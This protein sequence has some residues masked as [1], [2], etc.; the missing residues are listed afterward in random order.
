MMYNITQPEIETM[1]PNY[2]WTQIWKNVAF[3]PINIYDR[4]IMFKY[5]HE[6]LT[7]SKK[8]YSMGLKTSPLCNK[9]GVEESNVHL[10]LYC[11]KVQTSVNWMRRLI[12][13]LCNMDIGNN[14]LRCLFLDFPKV[15]KTVQNTLN[16][17]ICS[18]VSWIWYNREEPSLSIESLK[19]KMIRLQ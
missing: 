19:A 16:V 11:C 15:H 12:F 3:K 6:I 4:N 17:I 13:Y 8:L 7:N 18:Y 10:V 2:D 9:C 14:L 1:Y 5:I